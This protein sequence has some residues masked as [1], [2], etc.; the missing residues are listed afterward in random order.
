MYKYFVKQVIPAPPIKP[1]VAPILNGGRN[2]EKTE[3]PASH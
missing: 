3:E 2:G 1:P